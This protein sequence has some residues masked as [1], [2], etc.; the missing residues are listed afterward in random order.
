MAKV[1]G[2]P[3]AGLWLQKRSSTRGNLVNPTQKPLHKRYISINKNNK[4]KG[5][6]SFDK[7]FYYTEQSF[8]KNNKMVPLF[9]TCVVMFLLFYLMIKVHIS[10]FGILGS[11]SQIGVI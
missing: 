6:F 9:Y 3:V 7:P 4:T 11:L 5:R 2:T 1:L 10:E 8:R